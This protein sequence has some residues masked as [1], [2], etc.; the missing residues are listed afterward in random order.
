MQLTR[1][2]DY[3]LRLL[4]T[5][6]GQPEGQ[7]TSIAEVAELHAISRTHLMKIANALAH[8]GFIEA[9]RGRS[10]G[11]RLARDAVEINLGAVI[12]VMEPR[13]S[14]IDCTGCK[15]LRRC[16]LPGILDEAKSAF[17]AVL[18]CF[19]LAELVS[20]QTVGCECFRPGKDSTASFNLGPPSGFL[21]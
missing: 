5:L 6:A 12:R 10:G 16:T 8:A 1:Y 15:L 19:S 3:A 14:L 7:R 2:T 21:G 4:V 18:D 11:I 20:K 13:C 17:Q 9:V